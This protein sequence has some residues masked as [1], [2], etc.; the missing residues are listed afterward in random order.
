MDAGNGEPIALLDTWK[1]DAPSPSQQPCPTAQGAGPSVSDGA[2]E[3]QSAALASREGS[4]S[5]SEASRPVD[6]GHP[7]PRRE[8]RHLRYG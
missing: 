8:A 3:A 2:S 7:Q 4:A 6:I 5:L 1:G